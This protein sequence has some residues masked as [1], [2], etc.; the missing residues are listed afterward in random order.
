MR[1]R[2]RDLLA[3]L[4]LVAVLVPYVG[5]LVNGE[6]PLISEPRAMASTGFFLGGLA[7]WV[8]R[9]GQRPA[10]LG[11]VETG[12]AVLAL[13]LYILTI[14]LAATGGAE[15]LLA[16][17]MGSLLLVLALDLLD[18]GSPRHDAEVRR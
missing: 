1:L 13:V 4:L 16:A 17:F 3:L 8:I 12:A 6:M 14:A 2:F 11:P 9:G 15:L 10:R 5:Y 18:R 7:F